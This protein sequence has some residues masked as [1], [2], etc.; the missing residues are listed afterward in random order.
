[1]LL[2]KTRKIT[3]PEQAGFLISVGRIR[4]TKHETD[5]HQKERTQEE[6]EHN[7]QVALTCLQALF[8]TPLTGYQ[9]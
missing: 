2:G 9:P 4:Q 8:T 6:V 7:V 5:Y 1:V 3:R